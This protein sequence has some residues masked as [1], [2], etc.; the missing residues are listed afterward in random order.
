[1]VTKIKNPKTFS[2][3][4][5]NGQKK[6]PKSNFGKHFWKKKFVN[7]I[8]SLTYL[9]KPSKIGSFTDI[10][11]PTQPTAFTPVNISNPDYF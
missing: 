1:M 8:N 7:I 11:K 10:I 9:K 3:F 5:K 6:C 2:G 4:S